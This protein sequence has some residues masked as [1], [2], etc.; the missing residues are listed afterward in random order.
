MQGRQDHLNFVWRYAVVHSSDQV[1]NQNI[2]FLI[3]YYLIPA[4]NK[5]TLYLM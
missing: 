2:L 1:R 5:E 4:K 3:P